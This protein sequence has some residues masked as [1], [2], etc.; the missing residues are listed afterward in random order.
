MLNNLCSPAILYLV[1]SLT[2]III[3]LFQKTYKKALL[4]F[5]IMSI[6]TLLLN[7]LCKRGMTPISWIIVFIPFILMTL[8]ITVLLYVLNVNY[9]NKITNKDKTNKDKINKDK[10]N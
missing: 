2:Q 7:I 10:I 1:F 9:Y 4:K 3:D 6:F 8:I 5:I